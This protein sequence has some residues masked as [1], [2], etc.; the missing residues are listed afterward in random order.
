MSEN[1]DPKLA[2]F[3]VSSFLNDKISKRSTFVG[4]PYWMAPEVIKQVAYDFK[5][6]IWS[7]GITAIE[8]ILGRPPYHDIHPMKALFMISKNDPPELGDAVSSLYNDFIR[9]CLKKDP[10]ERPSAKDLLKH[11]L[12][13]DSKK[14]KYLRTIVETNNLVRTNSS[15]SISMSSTK[16]DKSD[17]EDEEW[18]FD[19]TSESKPSS[20]VK[21][22]EPTTDEVPVVVVENNET[23]TT[24]D[25]SFKAPRSVS[26]KG[27]S[28][29]RRSRKLTG[30]SSSATMLGIIYP[31][32]TKVAN[33]GSKDKDTVKSLKELKNAFDLAE[34]MKEGLITEFVAA[35]IDSLKKYVEINSILVII[36]T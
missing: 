2:D 7:L 19:T 17:D 32:L 8:L 10:D 4:T 5:A 29:K 22:P 16:D 28:S 6:D 11:K 12:F 25:E 30:T 23:S 1:G 9:T 31:A 15:D 34:T 21:G 26:K 13:K 14:N 33:K 3:G 24:G 35:I 18:D 27:K 20:P 36:L